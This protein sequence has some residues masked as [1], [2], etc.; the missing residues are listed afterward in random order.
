[1]RPIPI[2]IGDVRYSSIKEAARA[3]G[4]APATVVARLKHV[5]Q[6]RDKRRKPVT[7]AGRRFDSMKEAAKA[8]GVTPQTIQNWGR[9]RRMLSSSF[10]AG[11]I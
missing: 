10:G 6:W 4:V 2:S 8:F 11:T 1:M 9:S 7:V 3:L 5:G